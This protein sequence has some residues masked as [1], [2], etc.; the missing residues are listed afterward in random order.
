MSLNQNNKKKS[1]EIKITNKLY[2][3][4]YI[5]NRWKLLFLI[6]NIDIFITSLL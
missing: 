3:T 4:P 2:H 5:N 1:N 6:V